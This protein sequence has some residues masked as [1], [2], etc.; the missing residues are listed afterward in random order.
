M[1]VRREDEFSPLKN[2][3]GKWEDDADT[4]RRDVLLQGKRWA[5]AAGATVVSEDPN[6]GVEVSPL[7][8][9]GGEGL[10]HLKGRTITAPAVIE[11][12]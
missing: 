3:T 10:A 5:E 8:S 2:A 4:S 12:E 7:I 9:Y 1:E 6:A 11:R